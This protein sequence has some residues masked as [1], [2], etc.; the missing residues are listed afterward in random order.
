MFRLFWRSRKNP[1]YRQRIPERF[2]FVDINAMLPIIWIHA[3]SVGETIAAKPLIEGLMDQYPDHRVLVTTTT[4]TGSD[5]VKVLFSGRVDHVY[6]PYD[7]PDVVARFLKQVRPKILIIVETEIWPNLY[8]ACKKNNIPLLIVNARLSQKSTKAYLKI[9]GLAAET[10]KSVDTIAVRSDTDLT[11]FK[12][13]GADK[14]KIIVT[15]NIKYD[16][17][18]N[19][20]RVKQGRLWKKQWG[21]SRPVWV[22][23]STHTGE[24]EIILTIYKHL[25]ENFSNLV[26]VLVPRHPERFEA[27]HKLCLK[28]Q[29]EGV[30]TLRHSENN[31]YENLKVN[32]L[33][34]DSMGEMQSWYAS[35]DV[36]FIG[37]SLVNT[38][39]HNPLEATALGVP[40][41]SGQYMY[42]FEDISAELSKSQLLFICETQNEV[43]E[44]IASFIDSDN[45]QN[46]QQ[47]AD[48]IMQQHGGV[49]ARLLHLVSKLL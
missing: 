3:V 11:R 33:L 39:G 48:F 17:D 32:I 7:L 42:N 29:G 21:E 5:R 45:K 1:A 41:V 19:E 49:T 43:E 44:K 47:K 6:F 18:V 40:V 23:A 36:V 20:Q 4:P 13:L 14:N 37:G 15:G 2:G 28:L 46:I 12:Q 22:A 30:N 24:D 25:L 10:L 16:I 26:L 9:R 27:V 8:A 35:A 31:S 34:G 38:G